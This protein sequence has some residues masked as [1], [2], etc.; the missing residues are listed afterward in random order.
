MIIII[1]IIRD[2][3]ELGSGFATIRDN[4]GRAI[5]VLEEKKIKIQKNKN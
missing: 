1:I 3:K 5:Q 4:V 2:Q